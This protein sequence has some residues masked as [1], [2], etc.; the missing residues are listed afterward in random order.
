MTKPRRG[1]P[2]SAASISPKPG[3]SNAARASGRSRCP[4]AAPPIAVRLASFRRPCRNSSIETRPSIARAR[5]RNRSS[6]ISPD[7]NSVG[8]PSRA[9]R[10]ATPRPSADL[11]LP[12][13]PPRTIRSCRR[14]PPPSVRSSEGKP[15]ATVSGDGLS[16]PAASIRATNASSGVGG[17]RRP[18]LRGSVMC[19]AR[20]ARPVRPAPVRPLRQLLRPPARVPRVG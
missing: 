16:P 10:S 12:T 14:K 18:G 11:P 2:S 9:A 19:G 13:S 20:S 8:V 7:S 4:T 5:S 1:S 6:L 15:D 17:R 3:S